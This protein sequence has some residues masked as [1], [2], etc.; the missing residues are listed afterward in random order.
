MGNETKENME[1]LIRQFF[2]NEEE[3]K[4]V[5]GDIE[6]GEAI[7]RENA[8]PEPTDKLLVEIESKIAGRLE[9]QKKYSFGR[10]VYK[11]ATVAAAVIIGV[12][13]SISY[14]SKDASDYKGTAIV[15]IP[16]TAW[17]DA[18][19]TEVDAE[20]AILTAEIEEIESELVALQLNETNGNG[21]DGFWE[22]EMEFIEIESD[23]WKG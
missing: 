4:Q 22:L 1:E 10:L 23:F 3:V 13:L 14:F 5:S 6:A 8:A 12:L 11:A 15:T 18:P 20:L 2:K 21:D 9:E 7:L 19:S 17:E 16:A